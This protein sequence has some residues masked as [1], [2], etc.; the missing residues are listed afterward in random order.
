MGAFR[1]DRREAEQ[2]EEVAHHLAALERDYRR[3]GLG[4]EDARRAAQREFGVGDAFAEE[5][6]DAWAGRQALEMSRDV[7][8]GLRVLVKQRALTVAVVLTLGLCLGGNTAIL[9]VL[10]QLVLTPPPYADSDELVEV[11]STYA[12]QGVEDAGSNSYRMT[13][14]GALADLHDGVVLKNEEWKIVRW[15]AASRQLKGWWASDAVVPT[16]RLNVV[17]GRNFETGERGVLLLNERFCREVMSGDS[18]AIGTGMMVDGEDHTIVGIVTGLP[19]DVSYVRV[20]QWPV[21]ALQ[22]SHYDLRHERVG[23]LW[24]RL[25]QGVG[26]A[27]VRSRLDSLDQQEVR[28]SSV[29]DRERLSR[30]GFA[31]RVERLADVRNRELRPRLYFLQAAGLL[32]LVIG[33]VNIAG[34]LTARAN[35]RREELAT[36]VALG[37]TRG[38]LVRQWVTESAL[39]SALGWGVGLAVAWGMLQGYPVWA[40]TANDV[41]LETLLPTSV[42]I[43]SL[44]LAGLTALFLGGLTGGQVAG[45]HRRVSVQGMARSGTPTKA[46]RRLGGRLASVQTG[47][48]VILLGVAGLLWQSYAKVV[49]QDLGYAAGELVMMRVLLPEERYP[50]AEQQDAFANRLETTLGELPGIERV[51]RTS[52]VPT[53]GHP[54]MALHVAGREETPS[55]IGRV[56]FTQVSP[57][58]FEVMGIPI[59]QGRGIEGGDT[60]WWREAVVIDRRLARSAFGQEDAIGQRIR[61]GPN[62]RNPAA[63]PV[64]VGVAADVRHGG[65]DENNALPMVYRPIAE[66]GR[67]EF[68]VMLRTRRDAA[69]LLPEVRRT[70]QGLDSQV[71]VFRLGSV[72]AYLAESVRPRVALLNIIGAFAVIA[73]VLTLLGI[74]GVLFFDV[75]SRTRELG[76][77]IALGAERQ[78]VMG[79]VMKQAMARVAWG[80]L[81]GLGGLLIAGQVMQGLLYNTSSTSA[82]VY[83]SVVAA[84]TLT[85]LLA[86]FFPARRAVKVDPVDALR[87]G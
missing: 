28:E 51:A 25:R 8:F 85:G 49:G 40:G 55:G 45:M 35:A 76:I 32:V 82:V 66:S 9:A 44:V 37:A 1:R 57:D 63:W 11:F 59:Q 17:Q 22:G 18:R 21:E 29:A 30:E 2:R 19:G 54:D 47:V 78:S 77:R 69:E 50:E 73:L 79:L 10:H 4:G 14:V 7:K 16:L 74:A 67:T 80:L 65:W 86:G 75:A 33:A 36:R 58:Y 27:Q 23:Q 20:R 60:A 5:S 6:R 48:A 34:L 31:T 24:L 70:V 13:R 68:S 41:A 53:F 52:F 38:R 3:Q 39:L 12:G 56:A 43:G 84:V 64:V 72:E 71:A 61:L 87:V 15:A 83:A 81:P 26:L 42:V 62:P 46:L